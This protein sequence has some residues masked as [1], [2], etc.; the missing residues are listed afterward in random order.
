MWMIYTQVYS[1]LQKAAKVF[2]VF[3]SLLNHT[4]WKRKWM[5][6]VHGDE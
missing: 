4:A 3:E 5:A 1:H 2:F 6:V